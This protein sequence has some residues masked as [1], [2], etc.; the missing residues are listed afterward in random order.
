LIVLRVRI[1]AV[2]MREA[3]RVAILVKESELA[4]ILKA[5]IGD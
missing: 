2:R 5:G 4:V 3:E 1:L